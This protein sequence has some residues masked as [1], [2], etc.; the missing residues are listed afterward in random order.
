MTVAAALTAGRDVAM[1]LAGTN[2]PS[3]A[4]FK[5]EISRWLKQNKLDAIDK[6]TRSRAVECFEHRAAIEKWRATLTGIERLALNHPTSVLRHWKR[7]TVVPDPTAVKTV[8]NTAKLKATI[9]ELEEQ[10]FRMKREI[11]RGGGDLWSPTDTAK[12]IARVIYSQLTPSK[13]SQVLF[14]LRRLKNEAIDARTAERGCR[15]PQRTAE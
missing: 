14:E 9:A 11:E 3:G 13:L 15:A 4:N 2:K 7:K 10:N 12:N 8:S 5:R 1:H 6:A